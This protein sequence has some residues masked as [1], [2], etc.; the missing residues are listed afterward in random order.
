[1]P[2]WGK[3]HSDDKIWSIVAAVKQLHDMSPSGYDAIKSE[4][5]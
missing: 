4:E 1:M 3:T 2:A 5:E